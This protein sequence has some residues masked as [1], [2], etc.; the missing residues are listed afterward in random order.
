MRCGK[1]LLVLGSILS[2]MSVSLAFV[3]GAAAVDLQ[4]EGLSSQTDSATSL[5]DD[6]HAPG[7]A[8]SSDGEETDSPQEGAG[9]AA[10]DGRTQYAANNDLEGW[11]VGPSGDM[12]WYEHGQYV[13]NHAFYDPG[14]GQWYWADADGSI[15]KDK[16][17]F[18]PYDEADR[19][20]GGKWV[21]MDVDG[22]MVKGEDYRYGAWYYFDLTTGAMAK[23][24]HF[25]HSNGGKWV[26]YDWVTGQMAHG[27]R[28]VNY[29]S[30]HT[31]WYLFDQH[32]GAMQ[33]GFQPI[34]K[35]QKWVYYDKYTGIMKH[36]EQAIDGSW[37]LLDEHTGAV[38]Y[39][40]Q[41]VHG[42]WVYYSWPSGGMVHGP[43]TVAGIRYEFDRYTGALLNA[44]P[45]LSSL[46]GQYR[47][48]TRLGR[49][50][51]SGEVKSIRVLG[52]SIASG[53]GAPGGDYAFTSTPLFSDGQVTYFE[54][55]HERPTSVNYL[56]NY[57]A[58]R[59][60]SVM[61]ASVPQYGNYK[62]YDRLGTSTLGN[63][64]AA[65]VMLGTNDRPESLSEFTAHAERYL[66]LVDSRYKQMY[67]V[68][69]VPALT[70]AQ[71]ISMQQERD[72]LRQLCRNH[73]W[74]FVDLYDSFNYM[75]AHMAGMPPLEGMY[76][77]GV[78]PNR[79]GQDAMWGAFRQIF[80][81]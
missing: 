79:M 45:P 59:G 12:R 30:E 33:Y 46:P 34:Y 15:A 11:G 16:D 81:I 24:M 32:T 28:F 2:V 23:G 73:G 63:E 68:A 39:G 51:R 62:L 72:A 53:Y 17:V 66:S 56:R 74:T 55:S 40:W 48:G 20:K 42:K 35:L 67:V 37:Y 3:G 75:S 69:N 71:T 50:I 6:I 8:S 70:G 26:Y 19:S 76:T 29:D 52:D 14:S 36:G 5:R 9:Q 60:G 21:R 64:D 18:I 78:H 44:V 38:S 80:D 27:E 41:A 65:I 31:G 7:A 61:N 58:Q 13:R 57:L 77:D 43:Y 25:L 22:H 49:S 4:G 10:Q 47:T 1:G 54:P